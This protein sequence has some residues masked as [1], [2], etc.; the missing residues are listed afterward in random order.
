M[1]SVFDRRFD[2]AGN[3]HAVW[4]YM[5]GLN[6][7]R[8]HYKTFQNGNWSLPVAVEEAVTNNSWHPALA[9]APS[10]DL[11]VAWIDG[12]PGFVSDSVV[13]TRVRHADGTWAATL[14]LPDSIPINADNGPSILITA[15][16]VRHITFLNFDST[17]TN[18]MRY[19]YDAG[20]GWQG[21]RQPTPTVSHDP[22]LGP[23]G[24]GGL[25][26]YAHGEV[27]G[28]PTGVGNGKARFHKPAHATAWSAFTPI[29]EAIA[30][31]QIDDATGTR[32]SQF[33][34]NYPKTIDFTYW[35]H[36]PGNAATGYTIH[37]GTQ[38]P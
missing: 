17:S 1:P 4:V 21:D 30:T 19:W 32:W 10:G 5:A 34:H 29:P 36:T 20:S 13:R 14:T 24:S 8:L 27:V 31:G 6:V 33:F 18:T 22:V 28:D 37:I 2:S 15:D 7:R 38:A 16:G 9:F 11:T 26:I 12:T 3:P 35:T 23:D 25:Y